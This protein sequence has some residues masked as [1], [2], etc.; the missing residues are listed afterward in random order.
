MAIVTDVQRIRNR[1]FVKLS[2]QTIPLTPAMYRLRPLEP[3]ENVDPDEYEHFLVEQQYKPAINYAARLLAARAHSEGELRQKLQRAACLPM[4]V[5]LV[6]LK[7]Q[8]LGFVNDADFAKEWASTRATHLGRRRIADELRRK[9]IETD[10]IEQALGQLPQ[11]DISDAALQAALSFLRHAKAGEE[12]RITRRKA[13][14]RLIRRGY[15]WDEAKQA[16]TAALEELDVVDH[17]DWD[18]E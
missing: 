3:G 5:D 2:G 8:Q 9:G 10:L 7:L 15:S 6:I 16:V 14:E 4:T 1:V 13:T 11:E 17:D 12:L 18:E